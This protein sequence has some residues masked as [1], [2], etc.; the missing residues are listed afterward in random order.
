[1][2]IN[3]VETRVHLCESCS[4]EIMGTLQHTL[5]MLLLF[6][7]LAATIKTGCEVDVEGGHDG[8]LNDCLIVR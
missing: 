8:I 4:N 1:M 7:K 5:P 6:K 2:Q 3:E